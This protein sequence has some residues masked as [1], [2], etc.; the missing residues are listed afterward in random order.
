MQ[1]AETDPDRNLFLEIAEKYKYRDGTEEA[2]IWY[3]KVIDDGEPLDSLSGESRMSLA[4]MILRDKNYTESIEAYSKI[5]DDFK[6]QW[7]AQDSEIW[8]AIVYRKIGDTTKAIECFEQYIKNYP[9]SEDV[10][11]AQKQIEKLKGIKSD[12]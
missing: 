3:Q 6:G 7:F 2:K 4:D 1:K 10:I 8:I 5:M 9:E 12:T 11:Y